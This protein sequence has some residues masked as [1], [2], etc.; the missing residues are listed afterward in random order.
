MTIIH[1]ITNYLI[2]SHSFIASSISFIL[3]LSPAVLNPNRKGTWLWHRCLVH[4]SS[5]TLRL[6]ATNHG[7]TVKPILQGNK[8]KRTSHRRLHKRSCSSR[9]LTFHKKSVIFR[10]KLFSKRELNLCRQLYPLFGTFCAASD[11][12]GGCV[13][14][15]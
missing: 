9:P 10:L 14:L 5:D 6:Q 12:I 11:K 15:F 7:Y 2:N 3:L 13:I 4:A 8:A 1:W